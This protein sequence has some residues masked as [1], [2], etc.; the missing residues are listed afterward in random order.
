MNKPTYTTTVTCNDEE[1]AKV[2]A[3]LTEGYKKKQLFMMGVE[4]AIDEIVQGR[5]ET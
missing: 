4:R 3:C 1:Q 5:S 2:Q